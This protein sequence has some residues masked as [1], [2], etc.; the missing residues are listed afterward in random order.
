MRAD[1]KINTLV[2]GS[3][4]RE[5][6]IAHYLSKSDL[7][8]DLHCAPGNPGMMEIA[9]IHRADPCDRRAVLGLCKAYGIGLVVIGPEAPLAAGVSDSLRASGVRVFGPGR[10]GASLESSKSFAKKFMRR[11]GVP[12]S[13]FDICTDPDECREAISRRTHPYVIK[14]DGLAAGKGVFLADDAGDAEQICRDLLIEKKLG[15]AGETV[16]IE[17]FVSGLELTVFA[18][19]DGDSYRL[20]SP[21]RDHKRAYD[22]DKGPNTGG[23]GAYSPVRVP[24]DFMRRVEEE[25][26]RP[27]LKGLR[28]DGIEYRGV[29]YMGLML[30]G[31][32]DARDEPGISVIEYNVRFGDPETQA[33]LPLF[34][35]DLAR[36]LLACADG[37]VKSC[38]EVDNSGAALCVVLASGGYPGGFVRSLPIRGL[39][40]GCGESE[41]FPGSFI[42]HAGTDLDRDGRLVTAGGRVL[43]VVGVGGT[44]EAAKA[45]AYAR[46]SS[47]SF[48]GMHYRKDIGWSEE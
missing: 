3:G 10:A 42:F 39:E 8:G 33:V 31:G 21:S 26:I 24:N 34:R 22:G 11:H 7:T 43:T 6:S 30:V 19:T 12:T 41:D 28:S 17:D 48:D 32:G 5:H 38:P 23:M 37:D 9:A 46:I 13:D 4:G 2:L 36:T 25:V 1:G 29:I 18:I 44:F 35:G 45:R 20:M 27:T 40:G 14:A 16:V 47:I 15:A